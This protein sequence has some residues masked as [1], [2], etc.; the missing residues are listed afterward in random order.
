MLLPLFFEGFEHL[1]GDLRVVLGYFPE[2]LGDFPG[3][4]MFACLVE[5][6]HFANDRLDPF[7]IGGF[8]WSLTRGVT[9]R[10][11]AGACRLLRAQR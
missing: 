4:L 2:P 10:W 8:V 1:A 7:R 11:S 5:L 9:R 6:R 3:F